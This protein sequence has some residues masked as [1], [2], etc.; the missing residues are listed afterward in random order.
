MSCK[1]IDIPMRNGDIKAINEVRSTTILSLVNAIKKSLKCVIIN[2]ASSLTQ[3]IAFTID[4]HI[5]GFK[6]SGINE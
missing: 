2:S 4:L 5:G 1:G 6:C 3:P